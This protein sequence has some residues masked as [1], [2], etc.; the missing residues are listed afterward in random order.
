MSTFKDIEENAK[1]KG[2]ILD[3]CGRDERHYSFGLYTDFCGMSYEDALKAQLSCCFEGASTQ[4]TNIVKF[5]M[6]S[7]STDEFE[8]TIS[9][10]EPSAENVNVSF[11]IDGE[12]KYVI[13]PAGQTSVKTGIINPSKYA[14]VD[15]IAISSNDDN[16]KF[17]PNNQVETG[18]FVLNVIVDGELISS[19]TIKYGEP[20]TLPDMEQREGYTFNWEEHPDVMTEGNLTI[21]GFYTINTHSINWVVEGNTIITTVDYGNQ[22][23]PP[24]IEEREGYTFNWEAFPE[25]MPDNSL[26]ING[27]YTVNSYTITY[28]VDGVQYGDVETLNF[29][30]NLTLKDAPAKEGYT[31][32][33]WKLA[34]GNDVPTTMPARDI[35]INAHFS[36]NSYTITYFVDGEQYGNVESH[37]FGSQITLRR[38]PTKT[39]YSFSGWD[40]ELPDTMPANDI[41]ITGSFTINQYTLRLFTT[42]DGVQ[43]EYQSITADYGTPIT[44]TDPNEIGY[45]FT[46]YAGIPAT[47]P[48][49]NSEI[50][51]VF[52]IKSFPF[53]LNITDI[54]G[55]VKQTV[56]SNPVNYNTSIRTEVD[57]LINDFFINTDELMSTEGY[58][59]EKYNIE[60]VS[61]NIDYVVIDRDL[62]PELG[63][64]EVTVKYIP[65]GY[66]INLYAQLGDEPIDIINDVPFGEDITDVWKDLPENLVPEGKEFVNWTLV[67]GTTELP[68]IMPAHDINAVAVLANKTYTI[69]YIVDGI[70]DGEI[71]T[72]EYGSQITLKDEPTK[73]GYTFSGWDTELP[74][75]MPA[76]DIVISGSFTAIDYTITFNKNGE[77]STSTY[78]FGD[79]INYPELPIEEGYTWGTWYYMDGESR[80]DA[81]ATM[82]SRDI[83]VNVEKTINEWTL[84][85]SVE[86]Y[87]TSASTVTYGTEI[88][89][90]VPNMEP[91][92]VKDGITYKFKWIDAIP[93]TM[94]DNDLTITGI[95]VEKVDSNLVYY[96]YVLN[97]ESGSTTPST[98]ATMPS[99]DASLKNPADITL[100]IPVDDEMVRLSNGSNNSQTDEED[101]YW[102]DLINKRKEETRFRYWLR[103]PSQYNLIS[104]T[105][106][107]IDY[108]FEKLNRTEIND[109]TEYDLYQFVGESDTLFVCE[110]I[111]E[112]NLTI[113]LG[114]K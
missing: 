64:Y 111:Q 84:T 79:T 40:T 75:T 29:G 83:T 43:T 48:P 6:E 70:Q 38:N 74:N 30:V 1:L 60:T 69:T 27:S 109:D 3:S 114:K 52:T 108:P 98:Y 10:S 32:I 14:T 85:F 16:Y 24:S 65:V 53:I 93:G 92:I 68:T 71:E 19:T 99:Y 76:R 9:L 89:A 23:V 20:I 78:N 7:T 22:I 34:D 25:V 110:K 88:S 2:I 80:V 26:T 107:G 31:F 91:E 42:K 51:G 41:V 61:G 17:K 50:Y 96:G 81:P 77:I 97:S 5:Y 8:L 11:T 102:Q 86:G 46:W 101:L 58:N 82:P 44:V 94:P 72:Y 105:N 66:N 37:E 12:P 33:E 106:T 28:F 62:H 35:E 100:V 104:V 36:I 56:E 21:N 18:Y 87:D 112:S 55:N 15:G 67:D 4:K 59:E 13:V 45:T 103:I 57:R 39:G 90:L 113:T 63:T 95:Y 73:E 54:H 49:Y 47:M